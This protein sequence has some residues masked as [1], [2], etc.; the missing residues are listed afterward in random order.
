VSATLCTVCGL[1]LE[2]GEYPCVF[3]ARPH[4]RPVLG[5]KQI[6]DEIDEWN[7]NVGHEPVHFTSRQERKRYLKE[8]GLVEFVRHIGEP[9][10]DKSKHTTR[11]V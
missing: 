2:I 11:W 3:T 10:S 8:Q 4:G 1:P 7:E 6:G 9:G 5:L